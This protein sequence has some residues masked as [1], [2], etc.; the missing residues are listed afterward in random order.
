M[1]DLHTPSLTVGG[2]SAY[3]AVAGS[4]QLNASPAKM[5][6]VLH[7][8]HDHQAETRQFLTLNLNRSVAVKSVDTRL[9]SA[10]LFRPPV[11]SQNQS[12]DQRDLAS[13]DH[14]TDTPVVPSST[15]LQTKVEAKKGQEEKRGNSDDYYG[16]LLAG[17][18]VIENADAIPVRAVKPLENTPTVSATGSGADASASTSTSANNKTVDSM[19]STPELTQ[20]R[21]NLVDDI[22]KVVTNL[23]D[24]IIKAVNGMVDD[25]GDIVKDIA[26]GIFDDV[27]KVVDDLLG[28]LFK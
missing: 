22:G 19:R 25:I 10:A 23:I 9:V 24:N 4:F 6:S 3:N 21:A 2:A 12:K 7:G 11:Q 14:S 1:M 5:G 27:G 26:G 18:S 20:G 15:G 13:A 17:V 8:V 28:D 16:P